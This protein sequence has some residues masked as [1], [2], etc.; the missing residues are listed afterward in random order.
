MSFEIATGCVETFLAVLLFGTTYVP[1]K[2]Y[3]MHD[4]RSSSFIQH[5]LSRLLCPIRP[6]LCHLYGWLPH[7]CLS[8]L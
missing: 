1:L 5:L 8:R 6:N 2:K 4:G 3:N 7:L